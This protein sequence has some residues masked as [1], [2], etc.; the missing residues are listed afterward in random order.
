MQN[1]KVLFEIVPPGRN[2]SDSFRANALEKIMESIAPAK[3]ISFI[4]LPEIVDE[5]KWGKPFYRN[6][7]ACDFGLQIRD[8][9]KKE[10]IVNKVVVHCNGISG[11]NDWISGASGRGV[12]GFVFVGGNFDITYP[13]PSVID[14][15]RLAKL[16]GRNSIG[17]ICIP[18]RPNEAKRMFEKTQSG[19]SFFTTQVLF[20][21]ESAKK[22]L[23]EYG[24]LC[25]LNGVKPAEVFLSFATV[26]RRDELEF[27]K[28][29]GAEVPADVEKSLLSDSAGISKRSMLL[30]ESVWREVTGASGER[31]SDVPLGLNI[32]VIFLRNLQDC[33]ELAES[34]DGPF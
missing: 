10:V 16:G 3:G 22:A 1:H 24:Y 33:I 23:N 29:L 21:P 4:N 8:L 6:I 31:D 7:D 32:E 15:N 13:G 19:A 12:S 11:F 14:A 34:L 2:T 9:T 27:I 25:R 28:W 30:A 26:A 5:N 18:S 20:E 17:N